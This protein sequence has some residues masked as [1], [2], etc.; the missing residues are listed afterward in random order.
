MFSPDTVPWVILTDEVGPLNAADSDSDIGKAFH[1]IPMM[2]SFSCHYIGSL[3]EHSL[4]R[5][6]AFS[7][8]S[9]RKVLITLI[10]NEAFGRVLRFLLRLGES[11]R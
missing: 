9:A 5:D 3:S 10:K 11:C 2:T 7:I 1:S 8:F 4:V 6:V